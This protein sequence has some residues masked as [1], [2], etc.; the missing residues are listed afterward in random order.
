MNKV[1]LILYNQTTVP[2]EIEYYYAE[3]NPL[4]VD[5]SRE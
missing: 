4:H 1:Y 2:L 3:Q 5:S